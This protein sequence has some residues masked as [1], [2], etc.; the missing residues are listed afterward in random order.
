MAVKPKAPVAAKPAVSAADERDAAN[1]KAIVAAIRG[2]AMDKVVKLIPALGAYPNPYQSVISN[3]DLLFACIQLVRK[4]RDVFQELLVGLDGQPV[5]QDDVPLLCNRT[6]DQVIAML[7]RS[8]CK[9]YAELR[10]APA[11]VPLAAVPVKPETK[12]LLDKLRELVSGKWSETEQPKP[13]PSQ[14]KLF[15]QAIN[16]H[17]EFDWQVPLIPY[18]AELPLRLLTELGGGCTR[19]RNPEAIAQLADMGRHNMD[20]A[21]K[22]L[23]DDMMREMLDTQPLAAKGVAFLGKETYDFLHSTVYEQMGENFWEMCADCSRLEAIEEQNAKDL[24]QMAS[25]LHIIGPDTIHSIVKF[26]EFSLI[27]VF[28]QV[29]SER[30]G[31]EKFSEIFGIP[32]N[33][34]LIK[35]FSEKTAAYKLDVEDPVADLTNRLPDVFNAYLR[36]PADFEKGL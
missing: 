1:K 19:L 13:A 8:G 28:L 29:A 6:L 36:A 27:P 4:Q 7:V 17:L 2:P 33:K 15:Y 14:A 35:M 10:W 16:E 23:N 18:F 12:N 24:E 21:R 25:F 22:I 5:V 31:L 11:A 3:P 9:A 26:M 34:K 32:G 20:Q 30:L